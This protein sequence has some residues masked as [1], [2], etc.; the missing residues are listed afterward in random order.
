MYRY[1][2]YKCYCLWLKKKD[3]PEN[4]HINAVLSL[5]FLVYLNLID[6]PYIS[7]AILKKDI[8]H[9]PH[10]SFTIK[11]II[12]IVMIGIGLLN[13]FLLAYKKK[14]LKIV[15]EFNSESEEQRERGILFVW[16]YAIITIG[17]PLFILF[18]IHP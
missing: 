2:F 15:E 1:I 14:Y 12:C 6:I 5:T 4:A 17:I 8:F 7:F 9:L 10:T 18:F 3:E 16:I 13:Y 11:I